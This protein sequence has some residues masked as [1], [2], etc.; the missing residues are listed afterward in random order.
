MTERIV[1]ESVD[2]PGRLWDPFMPALETGVSV[3]IDG[4]LTIPA[5][6]DSVP[7]VIITHG[8][9][10]VGGAERGWAADLIDMGYASLIVDSFGGRGISTICFGRETVNVAS[11]LVDVYRAVDALRQHPYVDESR[12]AIMGL[13]FGGRTALWT[14]LGRFQEMY[15]GSPFAAHVAFYPSTCF[16]ELQDDHLVAGGPI[17]IFHG[18]D[19]DWTPI[20]QCREYV[21][22]LRAN[23]VDAALFEYQG[24]LH[25]FD[26]L[27]SGVTQGHLDAPS[28]R[29]CR[30]VE[31]DGEI[32][33]P[34]TGAVAGVGSPC[35]EIGVTYGFD[36]GARATAHRDLG[37]FLAE[38]FGEG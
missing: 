23:A 21:A 22:R 7:A 31:Q 13:S 10:G 24:A 38:A 3:E 17:R 5:T 12:I 29:N 28:P 14:S 30:F 26:D 15:D 19:D 25:S 9:G 35:V 34:E 6:A 27:S 37:D 18:T 20:D 36:S 11:I 8:C 2:L 4:T 32:L 16:I 33:D 1:I